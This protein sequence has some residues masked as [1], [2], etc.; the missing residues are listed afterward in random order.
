M[1]PKPRLL[2]AHQQ[3]T[4]G[5]AFRLRANK[6]SDQILHAYLGDGIELTIRSQELNIVTLH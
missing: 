5:M 3:N 1:Q 4:V 6:P 2:S